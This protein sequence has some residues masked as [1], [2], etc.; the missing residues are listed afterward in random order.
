M[1]IRIG[2]S[3][4]GG[5]IDYLLFGVLQGKDKTNWPNVLLIGVVWFFLY[6]AVFTFCIKKF[7]V[8]IPGMQDDSDN[9]ETVVNND[10]AQTGDKLYDESTQIIAALGGASN[11]KTISA[12]AT[13][14]RI[15]LNDNS[16]VNEKVFKQLGSPGVLKVA[17]GVQAIFGGKADLYSQEIND[18]LANPN[19]K[20]E[21][22]KIDSS[23]KEA[24]NSDTLKNTKVSFAAPVSG[25]YK[26]LSEVDDE[27][28]SKKIMG[29]G[30]AV[31]PDSNK[32]YSPVNGQVVSIFNTK[33]AIGFKTVE[34]L[35]VLLHLGIDTVDLEGKPFTIKINE[36]DQVTPTTELVEMD[37]KQVTDAGKKTTVITVITNSAEH[38]GKAKDLVK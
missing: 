16:Q 10:V 6:F 37:R 27:V 12:C 1:N 20:P 29:E 32:I 38:I 36:G 18:I 11:I 4:S 8:N 19:S 33:H 28:F 23:E 2:N 21:A 26:D 7:H 35:E 13:R 15:A 24:E 5:L 22:K 31:E 14:L 17:G 30:F 34:G 25:T 3:F 9:G